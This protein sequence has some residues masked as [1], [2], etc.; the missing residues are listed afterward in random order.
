MPAGSFV[1]GHSHKDKN[2]NVMLTGKIVMRKNG[3]I[4]TICAPFIFTAEPGRKL[5]YVVEECVWQNIYA[6]EETNIEK[7]DD[8]FIDK[9]DTWI[10]YEKECVE[11][12][13][14]AK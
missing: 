12:L 8:M 2:L 5:A 1:M 10:E 6:T 4:D 7:L 14:G 9:S 3:E 11:L 13:A